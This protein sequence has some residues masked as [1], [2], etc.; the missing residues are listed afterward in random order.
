MHPAPL[1]HALPMAKMIAKL[2]FTWCVWCR[3]ITLLRAFIRGGISLYKE[4]AENRC[5]TTG[6]EVVYNF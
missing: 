1:I 3:F 2:R 6:F 5:S 4:C